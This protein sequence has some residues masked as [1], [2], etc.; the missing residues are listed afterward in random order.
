MRLAAWTTAGLGLA[1]LVLAGL[2]APALAFQETPAGGG[3]PKSPQQDGLKLDPGKLGSSDNGRGTEIRIPGYGKL[4]VLPKLDFG[5][6][7]LYGA[8]QKAG[9]VPSAGPS[10]P[11]DLAIHGTVKHRF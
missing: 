1:A 6:E 9:S 8:D 11:E 10:T 4:G 7:L 2:V 5:L 3:A